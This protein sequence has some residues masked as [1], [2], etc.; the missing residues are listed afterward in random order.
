MRGTFEAKSKI[1]FGQMRIFGSADLPSGCKGKKTST[2]GK[3][4]VQGVF[5]ATKLKH[6]ERQRC[7]ATVLLTKSRLEGNSRFLVLSLCN[8][9][10]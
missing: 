5:N 7:M 6:K 4:S 1:E 8:R 2:F 9:Y 3:I 10:A